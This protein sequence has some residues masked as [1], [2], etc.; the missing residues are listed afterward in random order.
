MITVN[1]T[2]FGGG[3]FNGQPGNGPDNCQAW[4]DAI[5]YCIAKNFRQIDFGFGN[6]RFA[7]QPRMITA[8]IR[9]K[10]RGLPFS[11]IYRDY[12]PATPDE[13]FI[14]WNGALGERG[15]G[16]DDIMLRAQNGTSGGI[17]LALRGTDTSYRPG[18][19]FFTRST[20]TGVGSGTWLRCF[21]LDG[22]NIAVSGS[23]GIRSVELWGVE[24]FR[25]TEASLRVANG[26][27]FSMHGGG[28]FA[29]GAG[30][31]GKILVTGG[32]STLSNTTNFVLMQT[33]VA[34]DVVLEN[35]DGGFVVGKIG[36][37]L[38]IASTAKRGKTVAQVNG[39][40]TN[41]SASW[42]VL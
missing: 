12:V 32:G 7:S 6:Y 22:T 36:G 31:V 8:G 28:G 21:D 15:G 14:G 26:V 16:V 23:Q 41:Q 40:V 29:A 42:S 1:G 17:A 35:C 4:S 10:G 24:L 25:A 30:T 33:D 39:S 18:N 34:G 27:A 19:M 9:L 13:I 5:D 20:V 2:S 3:T 37:S 11:K 38:I